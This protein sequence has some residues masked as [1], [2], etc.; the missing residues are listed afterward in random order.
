MTL[1][2]EVVALL[3]SANIAHAVIGAAAMGAHGIARSTADIDLLTTDVRSLTRA[4]WDSLAK[5]C[6]IDVRRGDLD[7]PLAGVVRITRPGALDL[8]L[9][10]GKYQW[11][12]E[13]VARAEALHPEGLPVVQ[14]ADLVLLK[15]YAG[16]PQDA[17]DIAQMLGLP[18]GPGVIADVD[19]RLP[20]LP[21][22]ATER[23]QRIRHDAG[24]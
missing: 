9:I 8:D 1:L 23:W 4:T 11:Q 7:D 20:S 13:C 2:D 14:L 10:V 6:R 24:A 17:W 22:S 3:R 21:R 15:L 19:A 18:A 5:D 16:G 12:A